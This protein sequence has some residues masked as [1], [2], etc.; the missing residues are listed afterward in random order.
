MKKYDELKQEAR[1]YKLLFEAEQIMKLRNKIQKVCGNCKYC[2]TWKDK[3]MCV[4][5]GIVVT[6]DWYCKD[7]KWRN[8][9]EQ[10][11]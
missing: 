1:K 11:V 7:F 10:D 2:E 3:E 8:S 4:S 5:L 9:N 6:K